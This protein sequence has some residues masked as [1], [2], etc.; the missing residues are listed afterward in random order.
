[1]L[2]YHHPG[3]PFL[4]L[5]RKDSE[6]TVVGSNCPQGCAGAEGGPVSH[7]AIVRGKG[8]HQILVTEVTK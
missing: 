2:L 8:R 7:G 1:M 6:D 4:I 5:R 3:P